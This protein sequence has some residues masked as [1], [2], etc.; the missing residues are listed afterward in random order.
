M[1]PVTVLKQVNFYQL[2]Q[3]ATWRNLRQVVEKD[4][5]KG[6]FLKELLPPRVKESESP[7]LSQYI[8]LPQGEED[9]E[10]Q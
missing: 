6:S 8:V 7:K 3:E 1:A 2:V 5:R 10:K 4:F 9:K